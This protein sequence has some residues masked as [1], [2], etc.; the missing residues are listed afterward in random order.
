MLCL[1]HSPGLFARLHALP[2]NKL[3]TTEHE[4]HLAYFNRAG[5][6]AGASSSLA[7][8]S[9]PMSSYALHAAYRDTMDDTLAGKAHSYVGH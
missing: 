7:T 6:G 4:H 2:T 1:F 9:V 8:S 5:A 3:L